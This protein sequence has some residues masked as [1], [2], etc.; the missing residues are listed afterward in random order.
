MKTKL[1]LV[2]NIY[3]FC[4]GLDGIV[5]IFIVYICIR[6]VYIIFIIISSKI[7]IIIY[8][9]FNVRFEKKK[10]PNSED[11]MRKSTEKKS[12]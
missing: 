5:T 2:I 6:N 8:L 10:Y 1:K 11:G 4:I 7:K 12:Q 9:L 3:I